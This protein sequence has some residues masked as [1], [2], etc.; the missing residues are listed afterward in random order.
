MARKN[1]K[2][3]RKQVADV[4]GESESTLR[5]VEEGL[6]PDDAMRV[7]NKLEQ[8]FGMNLRTGAVASGGV[9]GP[10]P[11]VVLKFDP[12]TAQ[13]ITIDDLKR[14][15]QAREQAEA[16]GQ[17]MVVDM[18]EEKQEEPQKQSGFKKFFK[19]LFSGKKQPESGELDFETGQ[20]IET[21]NSKV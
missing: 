17:E 10:K 9:P 14:M 21:D 5:I 18:T 19:G 12:A 7:I 20:P 11:A 4:I 8:F 2:M 3:S 1:R 13:N 6:L 16:S 15:K